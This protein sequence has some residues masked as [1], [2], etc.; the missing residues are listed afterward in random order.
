MIF[1]SQKHAWTTK[2][3]VLQFFFLAYHS[4]ENFTFAPDGSSI[5]SNLG[6]LSQRVKP[7]RK[8][9]TAV[10]D[11]VTA[12]PSLRPSPNSQPA[13]SCGCFGLSSLSRDGELSFVIYDLHALLSVEPIWKRT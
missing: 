13:V 10:W 11:S 8:K 9:V 12:M 5:V 4:Q 6:L 2:Q 7:C 3:G 1:F